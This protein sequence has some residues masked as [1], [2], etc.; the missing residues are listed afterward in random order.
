MKKRKGKPDVAESR[1]QPA[2]CHGSIFAVLCLTIVFALIAGPAVVLAE[3][4]V[5]GTTQE[6]VSETQ[7][8]V[9]IGASVI[10]GDAISEGDGHANTIKG[11]WVSR[12]DNQLMDDFPNWYEISNKGVRGDTA[13]GVLNRLDSDVIEHKPDIVIVRVGGNDISGYEGVAPASPTAQEYRTVMGE[14][15]RELQTNLPDTPVFVL[16]MTTPLKK[17]VEASWLGQ[18]I[19][20][21]PEQEVLEK[22]FDE[23]ND[24]L[25]ELSAQFGYSYVD[26]PSQWP[27]DVEASWALSSDGSH[28]N[29]IGYD[30]MT[31]IIYAAMRKSSA[32]GSR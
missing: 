32:I 2:P 19:T 3:G 17:Y 7:L 14:I 30:K 25:E 6:T 23:Y 13:Q 8:I 28:P 1:R 21:M 5:E 16:G 18:Y 15:F 22:A 27:R 29:D 10:Y 24:V 11:G 20:S 4:I 12:L 9:A 26:I 31:E